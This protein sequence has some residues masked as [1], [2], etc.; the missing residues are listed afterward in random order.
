MDIGDCSF[1][2]LS[3][4]SETLHPDITESSGTVLIGDLGSVWNVLV[5]CTHAPAAILLLDQNNW[6]CAI[7]KKVASATSC[8]HHCNQVQLEDWKCITGVQ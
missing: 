8:V 4:L 2:V 6:D 7:S 3:V 5:S 1:T